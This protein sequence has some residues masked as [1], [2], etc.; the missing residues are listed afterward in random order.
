MEANIKK[1][2]R[3]RKRNPLNTEPVRFTVSVPTE[4]LSLYGRDEIADTLLRA[5]KLELNK[6]MED[7]TD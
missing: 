3:G 5:A 1:S 7:V 6:I 4:I 2:N